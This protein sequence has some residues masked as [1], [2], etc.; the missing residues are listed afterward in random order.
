MPTAAVR[1]HHR[2][3][4]DAPGAHQAGGVHDASL[5]LGECR[6]RFD[7]RLDRPAVQR[8][9]VVRPG[10]GDRSVGDDP[11]AVSGAVDHHEVAEVGTHHGAQRV[12]RGGVVAHADDRTAHDVPDCTA[13]QGA[14]PVR[15]PR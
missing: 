4:V 13:G 1:V 14:D 7:Q 6:F 12:G 9:G 15:F 2:D 11:Q 10:G 8:I 3:R 5:L